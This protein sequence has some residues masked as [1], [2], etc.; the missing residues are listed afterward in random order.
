MIYVK[1]CSAYVFFQKFSGF[2]SY[3]K[4]F[5]PFCVYLLY[6]VRKY[7]NLIFYIQLCSFPSTIVEKNAFS[8]YSYLLC[9]NFNFIFIK[10][11]LTYSVVS[12]SAAKHSDPVIH[13]Y[14]LFL[15]LSSITFYPKILDIVPCAVEW[16]LIVYPF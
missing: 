3:I 14:T 11:Y 16:E 2:W 7:S 13:I 6:G 12:F 1:E 5:N 9:F 4:V 8:K 15:I 10:L